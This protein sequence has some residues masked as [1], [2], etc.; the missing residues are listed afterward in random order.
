MM[1]FPC[2]CDAFI[3]LF[4]CLAQSQ[5]GCHSSPECV[6]PATLSLQ[7]IWQAK[8]PRLEADRIHIYG[9][10]Q[11]TETLAVNW[12]IRTR[13]HVEQSVVIRKAKGPPVGSVVPV[14]LLCTVFGV[15]EAT[16][17]CSQNFTNVHSYSSISLAEIQM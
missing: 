16:T 8:G 10:D 1:T 6:L 9:T 4:G 2:R 13:Y 3:W 15:Q 12:T 17:C 11:Y 5:I 7:T 14:T